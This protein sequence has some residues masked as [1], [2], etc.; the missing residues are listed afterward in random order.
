[1]DSGFGGGDDEIYNVYDKA[2]RSEKNIGQ[3][4]Y[5]P[6]KNNDKEVYGDDLE[7]IVKTN[8]FI[9]D[10][11][12]SGTDRT[13]ARVGPVQFERHTGQERE[14]DPFGLNKFLKEAKKGSKKT[15]DDE[16]EKRRRDISRSRSKSPAR[17]SDRDDHKNKKRRHDN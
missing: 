14:A 10:K 16:E 7:S 9:P 15:V 6:T 17:R 5:R 3:S 1:M 13:Q 12:F 2:W 11:E 8:R 4:I